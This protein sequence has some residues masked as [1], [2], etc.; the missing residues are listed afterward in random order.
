MI[1]FMNLENH[2][3]KKIK[4]F[5]REKGN[6]MICFLLLLYILVL[7]LGVVGEVFNIKWILNLPIFRI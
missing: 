6:N 7:G 5:Y 3:I 1:N 4:E 2:R